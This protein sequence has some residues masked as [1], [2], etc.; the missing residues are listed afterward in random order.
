MKYTADQVRDFH[1]TLHRLCGHAQIAPTDLD[2]RNWETFLRELE[3]L[4]DTP[5]GGFTVSDLTGV[6]SFMAEQKRNGIGWSMRPST[7]LRDPEKFRDLVLEVRGKMK[8]KKRWADRPQ[9]TPIHQKLPNGT[10]RITDDMT[11]IGEAIPIGDVATK[12][13]AQMKKEAGLL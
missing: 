1:K 11:E 10:R 6:I 7:I 5:E 2:L 8:L 13:F 3:P 4:N 12:T 9:S